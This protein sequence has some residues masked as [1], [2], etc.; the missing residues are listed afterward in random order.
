VY[1]SLLREHTSTRWMGLY[2]EHGTVASVTG[3]TVLLPD[4][5]SGHPGAGSERRCA[6]DGRR[7]EEP[8]KSDIDPSPTQ[9]AMGSCEEARAFVCERGPWLVEPRT[10]HAYLPITRTASWDEARAGCHALGGH[11]ATVQSADEN[12]HLAGAMFATFW[13]G[14]TARPSAGLLRWVTGEPFSFR[15]FAPGEPDDRDKTDDTCLVLDH[16]K[17]W[18]DRMCRSRYRSVCEVD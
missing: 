15:A 5:R 10:N 2:R 14:G 8:D 11:L 9:W 1:D 3:Q 12:A 4:W 13:I 16:D 18:H 7:S 17:L 6:Y